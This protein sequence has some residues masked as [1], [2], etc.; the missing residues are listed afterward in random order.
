MELYPG[1]TA[2]DNYAKHKKKKRNRR[3]K[4]RAGGTHDEGTI[5]ATTATVSDDVVLMVE[6]SM[7]CRSGIL[8][9]PTNTTTTFFFFVKSISQK[10][11]YPENDFDE[12]IQWWW[13]PAT[14]AACGMAIK[15]VL[16]CLFAV[17]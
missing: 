15:N 4:V 8:F 6:L 10:K 14:A 16:C 17:I 9:C 3:D 12:K 5:D 7:H 11:V 13:Q 1:W 2:R